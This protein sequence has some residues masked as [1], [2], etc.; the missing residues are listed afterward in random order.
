MIGLFGGSFDPVHHGH[1]MVALVARE[2]LQ[3]QELRFVPA[4]IQPFK[5]GEHL[6]STADRVAMLRLALASCPGMVVETSEVEREG[7][8]YTVD[9][10]RALKAREP[11]ESFILL[12]GAD[13]ARDLPRWREA[14]EVVRLA[15]VAVLT[16]PGHEAPVAPWVSAVVPVPALEL[17]ATDLRR[18]AAAGRSLRYFVPDAVAN[19]VAARG[20]YKDQ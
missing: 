18:R 3:L 4:G 10:L 11:G 17:S 8:S 13:A 15:K 12:L 14:E 20:L 2:T 9:T 7:P 19:Y 1:L 16:R 6:A 5:E